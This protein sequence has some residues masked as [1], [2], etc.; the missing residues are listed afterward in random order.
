MKQ[1]FN[2][3]FGVIKQGW[4]LS[5]VGVIL[6]SIIIYYIAPLISEKNS[7]LITLSSITGLVIIWFIFQLIRLL[8]VHKQDAAML[9]SLQDMEAIDEAQAAVDEELEVLQERLSEAVNELKNSRF[10]SK[11]G[12][13]LHYLYRI[14][15]YVLIGPPAS[16]KTTLLKNSSLRTVLS[17]K[18]GRESVGGIGGTRHCDWW[19]AEQAVLLDTA[20]RYT[21]Q[22]SHKDKDSKAWLGF[23]ELLKKH[24]ERRPIN[25]VMIAISVDELL[26]SDNLQQRAKEVRQRLQE[27]YEQFSLNL[28]VYLI[29]T[30]SDLLAGFT[31]FFYDQDKKARGQVWGTTFTER[32]K[33]IKNPVE[34]FKQELDLLEDTLKDKLLYK[35]ERESTLERRKKIYAFPEQFAEVKNS[36]YQFAQEVFSES[37]YQHKILFRG[38][39]FTSAEQTGSPIDKLLANL[40]RTFGFEQEPSIASRSRGKSYFIDDLLQKVIFPEAEL[41]GLNPVYERKKRFLQWGMISAAGLITLLGIS[42]W[43]ISYQKNKTDIQS[44]EIQ[45][46]TLQQLTLE[47]QDDNS[48]E[49]SLKILNQAAHLYV[50]KDEHSMMANFGLN[51]QKKLQ[52]QA[53]NTYQQVLHARLL[54]YVLNTLEQGL[55]QN[56]SNTGKLFNYLKGYLMLAPRHNK[57]YAANPTLL[58]TLLLPD[59]QKQYKNEL[60]TEQLEEL[61]LHLDHLI[62][63]K[64]ILAKVNLKQDD[65]LIEDARDVLLKPDVSE[66]IYAQVKQEIRQ[67]EQKLQAFRI[68]GNR[69]PFRHADKIFE[70]DQGEELHSY[71]LDGLYTYKGYKQFVVRSKKLLAEYMSDNWVLGKTIDRSVN[72]IYQDINALFL[73][74]Y[75]DAWNKYLAHLKIRT[76]VSIKDGADLLDI[77]AAPDSPIKGLLL[78]VAKETHLSKSSVP[79]GSKE[80]GLNEARREILKQTGKAGSIVSNI[81]GGDAIA[82]IASAKGDDA[83]T[84]HFQQLRRLM[85]KNS[86]SFERVKNHLER[87]GSK[88]RDLDIAVPG[89]STTEQRKAVKKLLDSLHAMANTQPVPLRPWLLQI[90]V[91][92]TEL[93]EGNFDK[94]LD[95]LS[96][97]NFFNA[98]SDLQQFRCPSSLMN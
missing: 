73:A 22:D 23:L 28:P 29:F 69:V 88:L 15:W 57:H 32:N 13:K 26:L 95:A 4:F 42:L 36:A 98:V 68:T 20:G 66:L 74:E 56:A 53:D 1:V 9:D 16:G 90:K 27:L 11:E 63:T 92:I 78:A 67:A 17:K 2:K 81:A 35:L 86:N 10:G 51:Q 54:P 50:Q 30:K 14:P 37:R 48:I 31:E 85:D 44:V 3:L 12:G 49:A 84:L 70:H 65:Q 93:L 96:S 5:L 91:A 94:T 7:T 87:L 82:K 52:H 79:T 38:A 61:A 89:E 34:Q 72:I 25:G 39:Y 58:K 55:Q 60:T 46:A 62:A 80:R 76:I 43:F 97:D 75:Q 71:H 41:A 64:P 6:L 8:Q 83:V 24:R 21:T 59:W 19:F 18:F 47:A 45:T 77:S 40:A 33:V